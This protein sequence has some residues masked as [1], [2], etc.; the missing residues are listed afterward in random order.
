[1]DLEKTLSIRFGWREIDTQTD[2]EPNF[3]CLV[4]IRFKHGKKNN[5]I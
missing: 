3:I 2:R 1:M 4:Q 5:P